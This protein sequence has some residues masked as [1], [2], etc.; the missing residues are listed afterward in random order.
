DVLAAQRTGLSARR[1][2][3]RTRRR[4][5]LRHG[6]APMSTIPQLKTILDVFRWMIT[7]NLPEA[8]RVEAANGQWIASSAREVRRRVANVVQQLER[9]GIQ[10][11][12]RIVVLSENR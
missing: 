5:P 12:D 6:G 10:R 11:G 7:R 3:G 9:W 4:D 8:M 1:G 2:G